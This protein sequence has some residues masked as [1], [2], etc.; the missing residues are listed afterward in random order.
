VTLPP[1]RRLH[2]R[3]KVAL[4][5]ASS[6]SGNLTTVYGVRMSL[7]RMRFADD[8]SGSNRLRSKWVSPAEHG[9]TARHEGTTS[10]HYGVIWCQS[11]VGRS[12]ANTSSSSIGS[13]SW[14]CLS[15]TLRM[16]PAVPL[17]ACPLGSSRLTTPC[18]CVCAGDVPPDRPADDLG[19]AGGADA[20]A[21]PDMQHHRAL[22]ADPQQGQL[23]L[24]SRG[25]LFHQRQPEGE[26]QVSDAEPWPMAESPP[27]G[28]AA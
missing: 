7:A 19:G 28:S 11:R 3:I 12:Q 14:A 26:A 20:Q 10:L 27:V 1:S 8:S 21:E 18:Y 22:Q 16:P 5:Y 4:L 24:H 15:I 25:R 13:L 17:I 9:S 2:R 23:V 6:L